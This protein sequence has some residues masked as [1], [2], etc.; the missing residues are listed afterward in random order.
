[1]KCALLECAIPGQRHFGM[2]QS[3]CA[4]LRC[5]ISGRASA[6]KGS[7]R[8]VVHVDEVR[9]VAPA[10]AVVVDLRAWAARTRV[11]CGSG[12]GPSRRGGG[13]SRQLQRQGA[14]RVP[15]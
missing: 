12:G 11:T 7:H 4:T 8:W 6:G 15:L 1:M 9:G 2:R 5:A 13:L 14:T 10:D 3:G